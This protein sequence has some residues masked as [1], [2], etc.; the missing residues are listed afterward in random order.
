MLLCYQETFGAQE[1]DGAQAFQGQGRTRDEEMALVKREL[2][3][4]EGT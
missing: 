4:K 2:A 1:R 3:G